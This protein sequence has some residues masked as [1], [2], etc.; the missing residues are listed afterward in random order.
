VPIRH[1]T[2]DPPFQ[3]QAGDTF[4]LNGT[5][6]EQWRGGNLIDSRDLTQQA[7][8]LL[9]NPAHFGDSQVTALYLEEHMPGV[10]ATL[11]GMQINES[12]GE[13][14]F[15][16]GDGTSLVYGSRSAAKLAVAS[17]DTD[18]QTPKNFLI[19]QSL[20]KDNEGANAQV[21]VGQSCMIDCAALQP[22]AMSAQ[23]G[24]S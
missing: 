18:P 17:L 12:N 10:M 21:M 16:F 7:N 22:C 13:Y 8:E 15:A 11:T 14:T 4:L 5:V 23:V 19:A 1:Y 9:T 3:R 24:P 2:I 6:Y 20:R